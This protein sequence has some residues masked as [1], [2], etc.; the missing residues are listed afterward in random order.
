MIYWLLVSLFYL[1]YMLL[2]DICCR[3]IEYILHCRLTK[4]SEGTVILVANNPIF[5]LKEVNANNKEVIRPVRFV[6][7]DKFDLKTNSVLVKM[8]ISEGAYNQAIEMQFLL[9]SKH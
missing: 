4:H 9:Q 7:T 2:Y 1:S 8:E 5:H 3:H 6:G